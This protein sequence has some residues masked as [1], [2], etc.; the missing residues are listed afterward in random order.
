MA[1]NTQIEPQAIGA[2]SRF[3]NRKSANSRSWGTIWRIVICKKWRL[4][5]IY[6]ESEVEELQQS[7]AR[8]L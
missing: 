8:K 2:N 7:T 1:S 5:G 4:A 6:V 3:V